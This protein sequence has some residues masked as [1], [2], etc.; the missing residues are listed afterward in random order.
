MPVIADKSTLFGVLI[1]LLL[2]HT[3]LAEGEDVIA[4]C[5]QIA[6]VGDQIL[7][8]ENA[9]RQESS[10]TDKAQR[11]EEAVR[12][13]EADIPPD[14][15]LPSISDEQIVDI[16]SDSTEIGA[17]STLTDSATPASDDFGL[18][19]QRSPKK[20]EAMRVTVITVRDNLSGRYVFETADGQIWLQTDQRNVRPA[21][22]PFTAEIRPASMGSFFL[23]PDTSNVSVR[24]RREK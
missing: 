6:S 19:D 15:D 10:A 22:T 9:L 20:I 5:A 16:S 11:N 12:L 18:N 7:C 13:S 8:L 4:R 2:A 3:A 17:E 24:V 23:K 1:V 14:N 21:N